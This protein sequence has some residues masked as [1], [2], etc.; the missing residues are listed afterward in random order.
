MPVRWFETHLE[1]KRFQHTLKCAQPRISVR[2]QRFMESLA[3]DG[4]I[5]SELRDAASVRPVAETIGRELGWSRRRIREEAEAWPLAA[6]S[7]GIDPAR[8]EIEG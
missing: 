1:P 5:A 4:R 6:R 2:R 7:E 3:A 8:A